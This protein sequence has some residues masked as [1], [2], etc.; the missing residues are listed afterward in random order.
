M[1]DC[2]PD[3]MNT[4]LLLCIVN[5]R[6]GGDVTCCLPA[7]AREIRRIVWKRVTVNHSMKEDM[8]QELMVYFIEKLWPKIKSS[9][10]DYQCTAYIRRVLNYRISDMLE[11]EQK[12][13]ELMSTIR[14]EG[15]R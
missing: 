5:A 2:Q 8:S 14:T 6:S 4:M 11:R 10:S 7:I 12:Y 9:Y 13:Q 1:P 15:R 3:K